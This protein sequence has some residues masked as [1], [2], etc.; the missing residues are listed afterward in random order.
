MTTNNSRGITVKNII[1]SNFAALFQATQ[2][3]PLSF[4]RHES[5]RHLD[6]AR[7]LVDAAYANASGQSRVKL[8]QEIQNSLPTD[9]ESIQRRHNFSRKITPTERDYPLAFVRV[10]YLVPISVY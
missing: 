1:L 5:V 9:C 7:L 8:S 10:A 6:C 4:Y 3:S 2:Q